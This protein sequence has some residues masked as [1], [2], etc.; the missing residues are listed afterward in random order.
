MDE[1]LDTSKFSD[2]DII[3]GKGF[4][5]PK[6]K[7]GKIKTGW[8]N[9]P[10]L[11][12]L[13]DDFNEAK[14]SRSTLDAQWDRWDRLY[15][16]PKHEGKPGSSKVA[17]K[18]IRKQVE[19]RCPALSEP[20]LSTNNLYDIKP[21]THEDAARAKQNS[22][23]LNRQFNTQLDK[24][25]LVDKIIRKVAK[26]GTAIVRTGWAFKEEEYT[27]LVPEFEYEEV[28]EEMM[29][30]VQEQ[31][32]QYAAMRD[33]APDSYEQLPEEL[34][35]S[36][37]M[38]LE[39]QMLL[40]ARQVGEVEQTATRTI[41]NKPTTEVCNIR[42][43][44][45]DPTCK[46]DMDKAQFVIHS[47]ESS[48]S[49]LKKDGNFKN[50]DQLENYDES[51]SLDHDGD[52]ES[53]NFKFKDEARKKIIV[54]EYWGE[55]DIDGNGETKPIV[56]SWIGDTLVRLDENPFPDGKPPFVVFNYIP[57]DDSVYGIPDAELL[58]D[59]QEILGA[60]TRGVI[61]IMG[62]SANAQTGYSKQF[63]DATNEIR[64]RNGEDY[65]FNQGFDPRAHMHVHT[66]PEIPNS[67]LQVIQMMNNDAEATSGVKAFGQDGLSAVNFGNTATGVRG[68]LDAVS[69]REMS[70]L[71]RISDGFIKL[72]RKIIAMNSE[73][74]SE[75]EIIRVTNDEFVRVR[76]DDLA[77][78]FDVTLTISTAEA[79]DAKAQELAFMLQT[80]GDSMG[81][82]VMKMILVEIA[83]LRKMP[84]LA[85]AIA[86]YSPEPDPLQQ[87]AQE[88]ELAKMEAEIALVNA[89]AAETQAKA[90]VYSAKIAVE[91]ARAKDLEGSASNKA[92]DF[93]NKDTGTAHQ[94]EL[95]KQEIINQGNIAKQQAK[96]EGQAAQMREQHNLSL[97]QKAADAGLPELATGDE[98]VE[99]DMAMPTI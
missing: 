58:G 76:R 97:L 82:E 77:G 78:E 80:M 34:K 68:V 79:D 56:A 2:K 31:Y 25:L 23:V 30:Q 26:E 69:K 74:L 61:D 63:L 33:S 87:K 9:Q 51:G 40:Q 62:K 38:S 46:G 6:S 1:T 15:E 57:E 14:G 43:V 22:L 37:E 93:V 92:L 75:E 35:A 86:N 11:Q 99:N 48:L 32:E 67:A 72:G 83:R 20:F 19:W 42:N 3:E 52:S 13:K 8:K 85:E 98:N 29:Q 17:P 64:F 12:N 39:Q 45:I 44:Y 59:N 28:P 84:D 5:K 81:Q 4:K 55:W 90:Q 21:L 10:T 18:L 50:L 53:S 73:F 54:Y 91:N 96:D 24:V 71:R 65:K 41:Y 66:F 36:I 60:V 89:E 94:Q 95:E 16:A 7:S 49:D 88:L 47:Y 27:E 70:V